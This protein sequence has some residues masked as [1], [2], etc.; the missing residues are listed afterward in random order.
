MT[1]NRASI[2]N[3]FRKN[4]PAETRDNV[5]FIKSR[6]ARLLRAILLVLVALLLIPFALG[7]Y[8]KGYFDGVQATRNETATKGVQ[9]VR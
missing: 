1:E 4:T 9:H 7:M 6:G 2:R 3:V 8:G 5:Q